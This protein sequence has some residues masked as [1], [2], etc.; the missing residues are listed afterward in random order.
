LITPHLLDGSVHA[1]KK[2][3]E[4]LLVGSKELGLEVNADKTKYMDMSQDQNAGQCH[5]LKD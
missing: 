2:I 3:K 1:V 4:G 5:N